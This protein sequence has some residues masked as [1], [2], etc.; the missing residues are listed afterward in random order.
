MNFQIH[1]DIP[2]YIFVLFGVVSASLA[3]LMYRRIEVVSRPRQMFLG[4]LRAASFF[5]L[6][7]AITN[8]VTDFVRLEFKKKSVFLL[9]DDSKSMSL[10]DGGVSRPDVMKDLIE[11]AE[12]DTLRHYFRLEPIVFGGNV[13]PEK[14][15]DSLRYD[16][17]A[18]N[19]TSAV[20]RALSMSEDGHTAFGL[21]VSDGDYNTGGSPVDEVRDLPF[22]LYTVGIGDS[23]QPKDVVV[24]QVIPAPS[25][26]AGKKSVVRAIIGSN[27]YG[28]ALVTARLL[29]DGREIDSR[30]VTL[31]EHGDV[32]VSFNY[33][34]TAVG[35][36][37]LRVYVPPLSGEFSRQNNSASATVEVQKG[38]YSLLLVAGEPATDVAFL[39]RNIEESGDFELKVLVQRTGNGFYEK[40]AESPFSEKYDAVI[41]YDFPNK[42]S[43]GTMSDVKKLLNTTGV[44]YAYFAGPGFSAAGVSGLPR[45]PFAVSGFQS[46]EFQVGILPVNSETFPLSLQPICTLLDAGFSQFPPLY[47]QRIQC[48]PLPGAVALASPVMNGV[49]VNT[50][51]FLIDPAKRSAAFLAYGLWRLQLMSPLSG[52]SSDYLQNFVTALMRTLISGGR[53][54]LLAVHTD[55]NVYDPSETIRFNALL[56]GQGGSPLDDATVDLTMKDRSGEVASDIRLSSTGSGGYTGSVLGLGT[57][58]YSFVAR[59]TSGSTFLGADSGTVIVEPLNTEYVRTSMNAPLLRQIASVSGGAFFTPA[60]FEKN[61]IQIRQA[62]KEPLR[63]T[64]STSFELLSLLPILALVLLLLAAEWTMRKIWGLP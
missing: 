53:Q 44:P 11:S 31:P 36:H 20:T 59:A 25:I 28:S 45:V 3:Y 32:E 22:P 46:G 39:R 27:G 55:K 26:Y 29:E 57:G 18:T 58:R 50:P 43:A 24:K 4:F 10:K 47:Y 8:L 51:V 33:T 60:Q 13:L 1:F 6:F 54:K 7:L 9:I 19:I 64:N 5:L 15:I 62:W 16:L 37:V 63:L 48:R 38:K 42:E 52:L 56:V 49:R 23:L 2:F 61:G 30:N 40:S 41:L 12:I 17:P 35:T 14:N 21:L 34:P